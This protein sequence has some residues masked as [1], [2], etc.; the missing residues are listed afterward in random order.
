MFIPSKWKNK[1][2][3]Y[4]DSNGWSPAEVVKLTTHS[5]CF[6][7]KSVD[8]KYA[9]T[10]YSVRRETEVMQWLSN[11]LTV[12]M[13]I[14]YGFED[15]REFL[16]MSE[17]EGVY[18]D[19]IKDDPLIYIQHLV[20]IIQFLQSIDILNCPFDSRVDVRLKEL[21]FLVA[22]NLASLDDWGDYVSFT[23]PN[24]LYKWLCDN[25]P[26]ED[27]LVFSHGDV[28]ANAFITNSGYSFNDL[29]RAGMADK[30]LD[31]AFCINDIRHWC[32]H[33]MYE[34]MFFELLGIQP[35]YEKIEYYI[36][37]DEMF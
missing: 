34:D 1:I 5:D 7:L 35:D 19:D 29:G 2:Q 10:T 13:V 9:A 27:E 26:Q 31:I 17:L 8:V 18:I 22:N 33:K 6:Y 24:K 14:D 32:K 4:S 21:E 36:L 30:W 20:E 23:D 3:A 28:T 15:N 16:V 25:R 11:K 12:P 37:L